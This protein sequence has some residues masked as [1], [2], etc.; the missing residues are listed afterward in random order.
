MCVVSMDEASN[1]FRATATRAYDT[2]NVTKIGQPVER[3]TDTSVLKQGRSRQMLKT[4]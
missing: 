4:S 3:S 1:L 2:P